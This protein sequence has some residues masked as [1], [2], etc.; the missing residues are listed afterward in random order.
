MTKSISVDTSEDRFIISIDKKVMTKD[1]LLQFIDNL[2]LEFLANKVN[3]DESIEELGE[4]IKKTWWT[5]NK[6]KFIPK[7]EQ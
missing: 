6:D 4:E 7:E 5:E 3:F 2:R 1:V